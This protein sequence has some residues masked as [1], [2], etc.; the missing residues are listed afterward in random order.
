MPDVAAGAA[1]AARA[2]RETLDALLAGQAPVLALAPMQ[3][4]TDGAFWA[5]V[6][7][8][9]GADVYWTEYFRVQAAST[10]ER[11]I[12]DAIDGNATGRP[13][14]AQMIG[15]DVAGLVRTAKVLQEH[16]VAAIDLNLGCPAP[17]VYR[18]CAGGGLLREHARIEAILGALRDAVTIPFT[19]KTR[20]G[21]AAV[22]EFEDLLAL[23]ARHSLDALTVH[24]RTVAQQY[25]LPVHYDLIRR[26][27]EVMPC[28][29]IANGHVYAAEQATAILARTG[30]RGLM[31]GRGAIRSPWLFQ[32]IRQQWR[33][34]P[35]TYPT[36][37]D[38]WRYIRAL[39]DS[40]ASFDKPEQAQC[41][42]M[43]KFL[44]YLG[45]GV[46]EPFLHRI[47]RATTAAEFH[48]TCAEFLDHDRPM[49]LTPAGTAAAS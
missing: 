14:V 6:H 46:A 8:Y 4:V 28:P 2:P 15:N 9:G 23:F 42:R 21:F 41:A 5:L 1:A 40:Q 48:G 47:R 10:P 27:V 22:D 13:V 12:L 29:V 17:I 7:H 32:Q 11:W 44:N 16:A 24:A 39:W 37:R 43:K 45:E 35:V 19:V 26:A 25:R 34:E 30:A 31:I 49:T 36:G 33:G 18:K 20:V 38:V 3:E